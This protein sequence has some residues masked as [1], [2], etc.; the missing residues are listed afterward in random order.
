VQHLCSTLRF[1]FLTSGYRDVETHYYTRDW[2]IQSAK[3]KQFRTA[4]WRRA[5]P[6]RD[7]GFG[8]CLRSGARGT[9][10]RLRGE[11]K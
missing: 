6:V 8:L 4:Q 2:G 7:T 3:S 1:F 11:H 9:G 5:V 10:T